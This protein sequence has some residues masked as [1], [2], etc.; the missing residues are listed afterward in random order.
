MTD[1]IKQARFPGKEWLLRR[2][3]MVP[4]YQDRSDNGGVRRA[5]EQAGI[6]KARNDGRAV[7]AIKPTLFNR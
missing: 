7:A 4:G 2:L 5:D 1:V 3:R 6:E